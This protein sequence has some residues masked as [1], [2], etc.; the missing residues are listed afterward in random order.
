MRNLKVK[1]KKPFI[2]ISYRTDSVVTLKFQNH[3]CFCS[4]RHRS[5]V[6]RDIFKSE[7]EILSL[8]M[9]YGLLGC[10]ETFNS[11]LNSFNRFCFQMVCTY[12][13]RNSSCEIV[14]HLQEHHK[15]QQWSDYDKYRCLMYMF[16]YRVSGWW[17]T[18][19]GYYRVVQCWTKV[20]GT[21]MN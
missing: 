12:D 3:F 5:P 18:C 19:T 17:M 8:E 11:R 21:C 1:T 7:S 10:V 4:L 2:Q 14:H 6:S 15:P 16:L 20:T 13:L 9:T